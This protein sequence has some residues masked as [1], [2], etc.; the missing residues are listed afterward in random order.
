MLGDIQIAE[1]GALIGFAGARV[2]E[3]TVREKLPDGLP[4]RRIP[5]RARHRRH[6]GHPH[7]AEA[8]T[9]ARV[10][11]LLRMPELAPDRDA[12]AEPRH[13]HRHGARGRGGGVRREPRSRAS[14]AAPARSLSAHDRPQPGD[15]LLSG[16]WRQTG[17]P[18]DEACRRCCMWPAPTARAARCALLRA[19]SPRRRGLA[20][21]CLHLAASGALQRAHPPGWR[22]GGRCRSSDGRAGAGRSPSMTARRSPCSRC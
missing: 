18:R 3:Q 19:P 11:G 1:A 8:E 2:I 4:A 7:R 15:R 12:A 14:S 17:R 9:L 5:A 22:T 16:C 6:G 10:I 21:S 20:R 13:C